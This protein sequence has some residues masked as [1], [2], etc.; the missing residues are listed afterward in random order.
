MKNYG[1]LFIVVLIVGCAKSPAKEIKIET[2]SVVTSRP[3]ISDIVLTTTLQGTI[4][5]IKE[6]EISPKMGGRLEKLLVDENDYIQAGQ[7]VASIDSTD[8]ALGVSQ[9]EAGLEIART[10]QHQAEINYENAKREFERAESLKLSNTI[11]QQSYDKITTGYK[12]ASAQIEVAKANINQ[13]EVS[14]SIAK[15]HLQ[16]TKITSPIKGI[17]THKMVNEGERIQ[18]MNAILKVMDIS[19]VKLEIA[20]SESLMTKIKKHQQVEIKV[21]AYPDEKF[22]GIIHNISSIINP[23][24]RTFNVTIYLNNPKYLLKPGMFARVQLELEKHLNV[25]C[26][27]HGAVFN[28]GLENYLYVVEKNHARLKQVKLGISDLEKVEITEGLAHNEEVVIRG[29]ENLQD[30]AI[31]QVVRR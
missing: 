27:P 20:V 24:S 6:A 31:V 17:I 9:A 4:M 29:V 5:P 2:V 3:F 25:L 15:Q 19:T 26:I 21:D 23:Q 12:M 7:L 22:T 30:G 8:A 10:S 11:A 18:G 14:L 28:R 1:L 16:D 13:A